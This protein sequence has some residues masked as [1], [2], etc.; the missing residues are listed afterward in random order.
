M[1]L[2]SHLLAGLAVGAYDEGEVTLAAALWPNS[3]W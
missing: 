2:R 3:P 1:V